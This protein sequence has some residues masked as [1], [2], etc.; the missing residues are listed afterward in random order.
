MREVSPVPHDEQLRRIQKI[1]VIGRLAAGV[2]NDFNNILTAILGYTELLQQSADP[3]A[4]VLADVAE[5][6]RAAE[7]AAGLT[8]MWQGEGWAA[9]SGFNHGYE[10]GRVIRTAIHLKRAH[11]LIV[12]DRLTCD[13]ASR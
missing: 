8:R 7:R 4:Q 12:V 13:P 3:S 1:D 11:A 2:A 5:I 6:R 9:A 10:D